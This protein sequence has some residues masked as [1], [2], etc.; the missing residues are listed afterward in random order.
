MMRLPGYPIRGAA[1][2]LAIVLAA[3]VAAA[4]GQQPAPKPVP[5]KPTTGQTVEIRGQAPTPQVVTVRPREVPAYAP[6]GLPKAVMTAGAWPSVTAAF[7][8]TP[9]SQL[10]GRLPLDTSAAGLA[11]GGAM[12]GGV[13]LAGVT[14]RG[15]AAAGAGAAGGVSVVGAST[16]EIE[17]LR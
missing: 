10:A 9:A 3:R 12:V 16:Q 13:A 17:A 1:L 7:S 5:K 6:S 4:Q 15:G 8:V 11:R 2:A 14:M